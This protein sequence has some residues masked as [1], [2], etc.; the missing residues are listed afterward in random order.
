MCKALFNFHCM[1]RDSKTVYFKIHWSKSL[2]TQEICAKLEWQKFCGCNAIGF[3]IRIHWRYAIKR[4][5]VYALSKHIKPD[6][7]IRIL[8][9]DDWTDQNHNVFLVWKY[10][11]KWT[12]YK[13]EAVKGKSNYNQYAH[14][15]QTGLRAGELSALK[16][17]GIDFD[18]EMFHAART[19]DYRTDSG[20]W[21]IRTPKTLL[22]TL[23]SLWNIGIQKNSHH[24]YQ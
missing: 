13:N 9:I 8:H 23:E 10:C 12:A 16:W 20:E 14:I 17:H 21:E 7:R 5:K 22:E 1:P 24:Y 4:C 19:I 15:L 11:R 2:Q 18:K 3:N 6:V